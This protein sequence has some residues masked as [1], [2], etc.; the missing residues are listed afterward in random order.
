MAERAIREHDG[1]LLLHRFLPVYGGEHMETQRHLLRVSAEASGPI[2][3]LADPA[4]MMDVGGAAET[5]SAEPAAAV[6]TI[7]FDRLAADHPWVYETRLVVKPDQLIKRR[8]KG[9][10]IALN[11]T[12]EDA[13]AWVRSH[14]GQVVTVDGVEGR[15]T[16]FLIEEFVPHAQSDE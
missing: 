2:V 7:N 10:L 4:D 14:A 16:N 3:G 15:L 5:G 1:K 6:A 12:W 8:G 11:V 13:C 9:G